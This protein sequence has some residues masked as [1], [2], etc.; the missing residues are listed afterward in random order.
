MSF[1]GAGSGSTSMGEGA[2]GDME[3]R[4][5]DYKHQADS[6]LNEIKGMQKTIVSL[7]T[8]G[9]SAAAAGSL[10]PSPTGVPRS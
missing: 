7:Q 1:G 9:M 5:Q 8:Q 2:L 3:R 10:L 6:R 4:L